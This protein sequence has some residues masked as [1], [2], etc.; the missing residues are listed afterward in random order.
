MPSVKEQLEGH[1]TR[2]NAVEGALG[3]RLGEKRKGFKAWFSSKWKWAVGNKFISVM[4][5]LFVLFAGIYGPYYLLHKDD[6]FNSAVDRELMKP[7]GLATKV[8]DVQKTASRID[9]TLSTLQ[10]FIQEIINHQFESAS[11]LPVSM[12]Q[13]RLPALANLLSVAKNQSAKVNPTV[14]AILSSKLSKIQAPPPHFWPVAGAIISFRSSSIVGASRDWTAVFPACIGIADLDASPNATVQRVGPNGKPIGSKVPVE[15]VGVQDCYIDLDGKR[16]S[17]W[18]CTRCLV[19]YSGGPLYLRDVHF[20]NC[21]FIL[22]L[23]SKPISPEGERF[24]KALLA[25]AIE[26]VTITSEGG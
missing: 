1:E 17:R 11:K 4:S 3:I 7:G 12:L 24:S 19:R 5:T 18:D 9:T 6:N 23:P 22:D 13:N 8:D 25:S 21:L 26:D 2:L 10:P 14:L 16:G 15:R 20:I